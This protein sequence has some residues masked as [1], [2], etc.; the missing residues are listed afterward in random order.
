MTDE[1]T[2]LSHSAPSAAFDLTSNLVL[3]DRKRNNVNVSWYVYYPLPPPVAEV[4]SSVTTTLV[5]N[6]Q[7]QTTLPPEVATRGV[8]M[9]VPY[10]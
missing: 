5:A 4:R 10:Y 8:V 9:L 2:I 7:Q 1:I 3:P 6:T